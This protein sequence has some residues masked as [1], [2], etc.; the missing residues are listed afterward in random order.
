M[1]V[2]RTGYIQGRFTIPTGGTIVHI[3]NANS[4]TETVDDVEVLVLTDVTIPAGDY[5]LSGPQVT[6]LHFCNEFTTLLNAAGLGTGW[7]VELDESTGFITINNTEGP[8]EM[9]FDDVELPDLIGF[10]GDISSTSDPEEGSIEAIGC[11]LPSA[12]LVLDVSHLAAPIATDSMQSESPNG[13]VIGHVG[14]S[15]REHMRLVY[16]H[17]PYPRLWIDSTT[18]EHVSLE[19]F[20]KTIQ[21]G[22]VH[23]WFAPSSKVCILSHDG[24]FVGNKQVDGWF[25]TGFDK[26]ADLTKRVQEA[27]D[28]VYRVEFPR[29]VSD[30]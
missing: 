13:L 7:S 29:L 15:R 4:D 5:Y 8:W 25:L 21:W 10:A 28:G 24:N 19:Y 6:T 16:S 9:S 27:W 1:L 12:S 23:D 14:N 30:G 18:E 22:M 11:W 26:P 2:D 20:L 3:G 17:V